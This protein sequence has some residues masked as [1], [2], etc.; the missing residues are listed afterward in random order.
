[1]GQ[2]AFTLIKMTTLGLPNF[3]AVIAPF[4]LLITVMHTLN[5]LNSDSESS[6]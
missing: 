4:A 5:R 6:C 3:I 2:S 1:M